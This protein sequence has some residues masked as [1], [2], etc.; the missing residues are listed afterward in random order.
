MKKKWNDGFP[1]GGECLKILLYMKLSAL[2][3][4]CGLMQTFGN[5]SAQRVSMVKNNASLEEVIWELKRQTRMVFVYSDEDIK[6]VHGIEVEARNMPVRE[7]LDRCLRGTGLTW[8]QEKGVTVIRKAQAPQ[9]EGVNFKGYVYDRKSGEPLV[10]ATVYLPKYGIGNICDA[11][12]MFVFKSVPAGTTAIEIRCVGQVTLE[13]TVAIGEKDSVYRFALEKENFAISQVTVVARSNKTGASTSSSISRSAIDHLQATN[14]GDVLE[15][16][17]GQLSS[18]PTLNSPVRANIRQ[19]QGDALNSLGTSI[20]VNG[21]PLSNNA[22]LQIG[23]TAKDGNLNT[24]FASTAGAGN[25]LRQI[26]VDN[27][28]SVDVI[29]GIPSVEYGD[30]TSGVIIVNPRAGKYPLQA[31]VKINPVLTQASL[32]KGFDLGQKG[33]SLNVDFDYAHSLTDE[34]RPNQSFRRI[35]ANALYSNSF[36]ERLRTNTSLSF[37]TDL[38]ASKL[39]PSDVRYQRK[40]TSENTGIRFNTNWTLNIEDSFLKYLRMNLSANYEIQNGFNQEIKN[41]GGYMITTATKDG[42]VASNR[43]EEIVD[44]NGA[45]VTNLATVDPKAVTDFL[46]YEYLAQFHI[47]GRPLNVFGK[48]L[49]N[50]YGEAGGIGNRILLGGDWK[51]DVNFGDGKVFDPKRPP[52]GG[53]RMRP[54]R[55]IPALHQLGVFVEDNIS[56][57]ILQRAFKLQLG[58]RYDHIGLGDEHVGKVF[59]PRVNASYEIVREKVTLKGGWGITAKAPTLMYLYPDPGYYD[60]V[61]Y[62]NIGEPDLPD[63]EKLYILTTKVYDTRNN[64]L[65]IARNR[66]AE[67][68]ADI[69][70]GQMNFSVTAF[71]EKLKNGYSFATDMDSWQLFDLVKY[72]GERRA[73][74]YPLLT[75]DKVVN[76]MLTSNRPLNN[77]VNKTEGIEFDLNFGRVDALHTS[78]VFNGAWMVTKMY[79]TNPTFYQQSE[80]NGVYPDVGVYASGDGSRY[81]RFSTTLRVISNIPKAGFVVSL[82]VQTIWKDTHDFLG[83]ENTRPVGYISAQDLSYHTIGA[84]EAI[85][86]E[87]QRYLSESRGVTD[88]YDPLW[89]FNL[90]VTKEVGSYLGFAFFVNNLFMHLPKEESTRTPG[91]YKTR[92]PEQFFG[93]EVWV[94]F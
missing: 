81:E 27:I 1:R 76:Q 84:D 25:D 21:A 16:L 93:A 43:G 5:V 40:R 3:L 53:L 19:V 80:K 79:N 63:E 61:N 87:L 74:T 41:G 29:R 8:L 31:R 6:A 45:A 39:D 28:E 85:R 22:N 57:T 10:A 49:A 78:F 48:V 26:A 51:T 90:R 77:K 92:N 54:Y 7:V 70:L 37:Y 46:P 62:Q 12:G 71:S 55:D 75:V 47:K 14:L 64:D 73:G 15:L 24:N 13:T 91:S 58:L 9:D 83:L 23:N 82:A 60:Y 33:G 66:K 38:D 50:F 17:P 32:G 20:I 35:T 52:E 44:G 69:R 94:R 4:F 67:I 34:R 59:S 56:A 86:P 68:G 89:L 2:F 42:A 65:K 88:K 11:R 30:L 18:N 72:K 36:Y